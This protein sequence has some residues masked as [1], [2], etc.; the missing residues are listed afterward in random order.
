MFVGVVFSAFRHGDV[1]TRR[2]NRTWASACIPFDFCA[3]AKCDTIGEEGNGVGMPPQQ[4]PRQHENRLS[5][6]R[7]FSIVPWLRM[8]RPSWVWVIISSLHMQQHQIKTMFKIRIVHKM[9]VIWLSLVENPRIHSFSASASLAW[10]RSGQRS[11]AQY[12]KR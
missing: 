6:F 3:S 4:Q 10:A 5:L 9:H 8:E 12:S 1:P 11:N 2:W 7:K